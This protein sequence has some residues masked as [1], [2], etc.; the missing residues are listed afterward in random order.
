MSHN[1]WFHRIA[2]VTVRPLA[3][4]AVTPNQL[5]TVR[6]GAGLGAGALLA[7]GDPEMLRWGAVVFLVS[8][9][10]DRADGELAR[11]TGQMSSGGHRYD[12]MADSI[13]NV[14]AFVGLGIG[15]RGG[16]WG[17]QAIL[18]GIAAGLAVA[19]VL[20]MVIMLESL[21]GERAGESFRPD[22]F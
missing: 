17:N 12:L 10:L 13:C 21:G 6:L 1:T 19:A 11:L 5:T 18:M 3:G 16:E 22:S 9:L 8:M 7:V 20:M 15:L 14:A 4:T 2:R